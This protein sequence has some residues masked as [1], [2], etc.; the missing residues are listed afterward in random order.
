MFYM[1]HPKPLIR[2]S[3]GGIKVLHN[4]ILMPLDVNFML[5]FRDMGLTSK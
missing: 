4:I 3:W 1:L 2:M 5:F